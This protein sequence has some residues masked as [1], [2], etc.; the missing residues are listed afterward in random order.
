MVQVLNSWEKGL[1]VT[2]INNLSHP[3]KVIGVQI[4]TLDNQI[5]ILYERCIQTL[6]YPSQMYVHCPT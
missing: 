5:V 3:T 2:T 4:K 1:D 6:V